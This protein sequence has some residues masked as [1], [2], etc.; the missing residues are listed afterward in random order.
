[1]KG[2]GGTDHTVS[3]LREPN[4]HRNVMMVQPSAPTIKTL[5]VNTGMMGTAPP[6][7][8]AT[9]LRSVG[10]MAKKGIKFNFFPRIEFFTCISCVRSVM[11]VRG[12]RAHINTM[13][14]ILSKS[15]IY[16]ENT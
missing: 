4:A 1:M 2:V 8:Q 15:S 3:G 11:F 12:L 10:V 9:R 13:Y 5:S 7:C 6:C 16:G 14:A